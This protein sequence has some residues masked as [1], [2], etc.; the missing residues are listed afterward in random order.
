MRHDIPERAR[1]LIDQ[2]QLIAHPEGG[3]Y[4]ERYRAPV[5]SADER[6][7]STSIYFL[8]TEGERSKLHRIDADEGWHHYEGDPVRVHSIDRGQHRWFD[9][10]PLLEGREPQGFVSAGLWFG[11]E[12]LLGANGYA[13]VGCTVAPAFDFRSFELASQAELLRAYP[14]HE[15]LIRRL[16]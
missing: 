7:A 14:Q 8:L 11:A 4:R 9:V 16:T 1:S 2:L 3:W 15:P 13:L 10:G 6:A 12:L 5:S